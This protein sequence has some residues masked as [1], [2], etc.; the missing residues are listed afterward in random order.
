MR[1]E[2]RLLLSWMLDA[3]TIH[4]VCRL[5]VRVSGR[6]PGQAVALGDAPTWT[7]R[8]EGLK[9]FAGGRTVNADPW[10]CFLIGFERISPCR[11]E[12]PRRRPV[13]SNC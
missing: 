1:V 6:D 2:E 9:R 12:Q 13:T 10:R 8:A 4:P 7:A 5:W 11:P 3:P